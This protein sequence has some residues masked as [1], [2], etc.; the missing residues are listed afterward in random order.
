MIRNALLFDSFIDIIVENYS[1]IV[2]KYQ[3]IWR[4]DKLDSQHWAH[5]WK[6]SVLTFK[7]CLYHKLDIVFNSIKHTL[8]KHLFGE[9]YTLL[10]SLNITQL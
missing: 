7:L 10:L 4:N 5:G 9:W 8:S 2:A 6:S 1:T 3:F